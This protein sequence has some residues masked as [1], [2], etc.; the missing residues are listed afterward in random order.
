MTDPTP[1]NNAILEAFGN[2]TEDQ[3]ASIIFRNPEMVKKTAKAAVIARAKAVEEEARLAPKRQMKGDEKTYAK[4]RRLVESPHNKENVA[5]F[6]SLVADFD[7]SWKPEEQPSVLAA[8]LNYLASKDRVEPLWISDISDAGPEISAADIVAAA[9]CI[10]KRYDVKTNVKKILNLAFSK[11][12]PWAEMEGEAIR[13]ASTNPAAKTLSDGLVKFIWE[14]DSNRNHSED[15]LSFK[16]LVDAG[17][18]HKG[19]SEMP[20]WQ[21]VSCETVPTDHNTKGPL[22]TD[23]DAKISLFASMIK[24]GWVNGGVSDMTPSLSVKNSDFFV[25]N[26]KPIGH[27]KKTKA[28]ARGDGIFDPCSSRALLS[29]CSADDTLLPILR[30]VCDHEEAC[31]MDVAF[32]I[33]GR[34]RLFIANKRLWDCSSGYRSS[35]AIIETWRDVIVECLARG[36]SI[37]S[38]NCQNPY[39]SAANDHVSEILRSVSEART[40]ESSANGL[41]TAGPVKT[42]KKK[43]G[44]VSI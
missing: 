22:K 34:S 29:K 16:T 43:A 20:F 28:N 9:C 36:D 10:S 27:G 7:I 33:L 38:V 14:I 30:A 37:E 26:G 11:P 42:S 24:M 12:G 17:C 13:L 6:K 25:R 18:S 21:M 23:V 40:M 15:Y 44:P 31:G 35:D 8:C 3:I 19:F 41:L 5:V 1:D 4:V 32:D 39:A 2:L